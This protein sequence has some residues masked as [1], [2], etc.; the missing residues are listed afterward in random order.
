[1]IEV[2]RIPVPKDR[3][4]A[5]PKDERVLLLLLGYVSNQ[6]LM[7][8]KL[9]IYA[10]RLDPKDEVEE[11]AT[12]VQTQML[13]R[14][15]VSAAFQA[16]RLI[17]TRFLSNPLAKDYMGRLDRDGLQA[18]EELRR[19]FGK[20]ALLSAIRNNFGFHYPE[21]ADAEVAFQAAADDTGFDD[22]W[23]V[24]LSQHGFNSLFL[25]SDAVFAHGIAAQLG[26]T[27]L[28]ALQQKLMVELR[29]ASMNVVQFA[30]AFFAAAWIK[31]FGDVIDAQDVVKIEG[32]PLL[33]EIA[34]P[35]FVEIQAG[36]SHPAA[37]A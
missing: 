13:V 9:L 3:L 8:Q 36:E 6:V 15:A 14:I 27:D 16:W 17:E 1:M 33:E 23:K 11:H 4:R 20:S 31:H 37:S 18:L 22:I 5:L 26:T 28:L 30:Q 34:L 19:H 32:A 10:T 21:T 25:L 35:F 7:L 24:Y 29:E 2:Y 12:G